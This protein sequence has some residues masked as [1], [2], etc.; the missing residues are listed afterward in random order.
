MEDNTIVLD[1][2][3]DG[4]VVKEFTMAGKLIS[5]KAV[6]RGGVKNILRKAWMEIGEVRIPDAPDNVFVFS[7]KKKEI[8]D[9]ILEESPWSA[10]GQL[11]NLKQWEPS[12][13]LEDIDF[14]KVAFWIQV[15]GLNRDLLTKKNA[16]RIGASLGKVV[17]VENPVGDGGLVRG[18]LRCRVEIDLADPLKDGFWVP[19][20]NG[21]RRWASL[22][23][24]KLS[25]CCYN[26]GCIGHSEKMCDEEPVVAIYDP[27]LLRYGPWMRTAAV[28][29]I[30]EDIP[31][32]VKG[33]KGNDAREANRQIWRVG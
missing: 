15:H 10:M 13:A 19:C 7:M 26:C 31:P 9:Q 5:E 11:V 30:S 4:E 1:P 27:E 33:G 23:Y 2:G 25:D 20:S 8:M 22:R 3:D 6:N 28:R 21:D 16:E 32:T 29:K 12:E 18:F 24:E 14:S 17:E